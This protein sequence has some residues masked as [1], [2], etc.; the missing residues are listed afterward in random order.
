[1]IYEAVVVHHG[2]VMFHERVVHETVDAKNEIHLK[3][4][5]PVSAA[6]QGWIQVERGAGGALV[7][8]HETG[9]LDSKMIHI[10]IPFPS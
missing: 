4:T 1:M 10:R 7:K 3:L 5:A 8:P 2:T 6:A 9:F